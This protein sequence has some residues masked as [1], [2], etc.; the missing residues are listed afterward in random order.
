MRVLIAENSPFLGQALVSLVRGEGWDVAGLA[1]NSADAVALA[2]SERPDLALIDV[3][4]TDHIGGEE[5][6]G[7]I[8]REKICPTL[9]TTPRPDMVDLGLMEAEGVLPK[10]F[11]DEDLLGALKAVW[12]KARGQNYEM[13]RSVIQATDPASGRRAAARRGTA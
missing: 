13:P 9:L 6:S 1:D 8:N 12:R 2:R 3:H 7:W 5:V 10:P 4:L 11:G